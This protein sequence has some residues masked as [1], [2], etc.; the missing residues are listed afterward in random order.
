M[1]YSK[2][3]SVFDLSFFHKLDLYQ[4]NKTML[5]WH[6]QCFFS[7]IYCLC[8]LWGNFNLVR[9]VK[10]SLGDLVFSEILGD[11][12][13]F[14]IPWI[15]QEN[16]K[17]MQIINYKIYVDSSYYGKKIKCY[18]TVHKFR[19]SFFKKVMVPCTLKRHFKI[20]LLVFFLNIRLYSLKST[21]TYDN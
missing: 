20:S 3:G 1:Q 6:F 9:R 4:V 19:K 14:R 7:R 5:N 2:F 8:Q 16:V 12:E 18:Y 17:N 21:Q 10:I 11:I 15:Y 13:P